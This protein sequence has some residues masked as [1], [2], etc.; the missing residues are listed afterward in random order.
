MDIQHFTYLLTILW[1]IDQ[2]MVSL[3]SSFIFFLSFFLRIVLVFV[4]F[5]LV[6][7]YLSQHMKNPNLTFKI[8]NFQTAMYIKTHRPF[9]EKM[10]RS[11]HE[12][13][14]STCLTSSQEMLMPLMDRLLLEHQGF[15]P[16]IPLKKNVISSLVHARYTY[17]CFH[18][19]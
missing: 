12:A 1:T 11:G 19:F 17:I 3:L 18:K 10:N 5:K 9:L 4:N 14:D 16:H 2:E 13:H 7:G 6:I 15:Q 8:N